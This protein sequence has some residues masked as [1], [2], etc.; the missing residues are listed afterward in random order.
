[1]GS[2]VTTSSRYYPSSGR[3]RENL[4]ILSTGGL[5]CSRPVKRP[6]LLSG[7]GISRKFRPW[8]SRPGSGSRRE[9]LIACH[10]R[11]ALIKT[12]AKKCNEHSLLRALLEYELIWH[13][14]RDCCTSTIKTRSR[15][16]RYDNP[17]LFFSSTLDDDYDDESWFDPFRWVFHYQKKEK[18]QEW[19][20][21]YYVIII[22]LNLWGT[23]LHSTLGTTSVLLRRVAFELLASVS[24]YHVSTTL[25]RS[26]RNY[27]RVCLI[28]RLAL[29]SRL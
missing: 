12:V 1:M 16:Q 15:E 3:R 29:L 27:A 28:S 8:S 13:D 25:D 22:T 10:A 21:I 14:C 2:F 20:R 5:G 17:I 9:S 26:V 23:L 6:A 11:D 18:K 7:A 4:R 19:L 24:M